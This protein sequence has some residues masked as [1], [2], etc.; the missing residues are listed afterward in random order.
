MDKRNFNCACVAGLLAVVVAVPFAVSRIGHDGTRGAAPTVSSATSRTMPSQ[1]ARIADDLNRAREDGDAGAVLACAEAARGCA[2]AAIRLEAVEALEETGA[3]GFAA[4]TA[5]LGDGDADVRESAASAWCWTVSEFDSDARKI[6]EIES[7]LTT[8]SDP[9][10]LEQIAAEYIGL[11]DRQ[12][13]ESLVRLIGR[14]LSPV[15]RKQA[16]EVYESVTGD[17]WVSVESARAWIA[18]SCDESV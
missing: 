11:D 10:V 9:D 5:F 14:N 1:A 2:D 17:E 8:F 4:L 12:V 6:R 3:A 16:L 7:A 18:A 13:V 15:A